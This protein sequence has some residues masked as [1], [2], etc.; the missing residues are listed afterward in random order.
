MSFT[1]GSYEK[2][3]IALF[4]NL[5]YQHQYGPNIERDYYVPFYEEQLI[6]S[7]TTINY[8]KP[9]LA[10]DEAISKLKDIEIGSLPQRNELFMDYL[11]HGIEVSFFD[12]KEQ[13]NDIIYLI[14]YND[15]NI[16][17]NDFKV[18]NQ[19]TFVENS[20]KR[21]DIILFVNGLPLV[22]IELK[23]PSR[24]ETNVS[25]AYLQLRN[26]MK[27]IPSLFVYNVFCVMS[28]MACS[29]AGT[30]TSNEDRY[31]EWKT[32]DGKYE[33]S[34]FI[35]YDTFFEG[36]FIKERFIDIIKN[37]I[38][39]SKEESGAAKI[40]A[41]YHQY[42]AVKKAVERTKKA[43]QGDGKIGVFW[44]TQGSGKSLSMVFYAHLLQDELSQPTIVVITDRNDLDDQL[45]TQFSKCQQFLRQIPIQ[46]KSREDLKSL[47][48]GREANGIIFTTMQKFEE[49]DEPLSL[50]RNIVV[51]TDEAHRG[52][53]GFEEKVNEETGK[54]SIGTARIIHNSLPNASFIGFTGTPIS[55]K[56]RDTT[57]VFGDY[58]DI[59]DMTQAVSDGATCP[60]YYESRVINLNLDKDTLK[61]IDDEYEILASEGATEEQIE[62][63][64]KQMSHLEEILGAPATIDSL[65]KDIINHYEEN[66][67]FELTGKAMIVAY[68]R[69][70]AMSIY[71]RILELRPDWTDKVK[72]VMTGSNKDPEE[73]HDIIGNKQYKKELAKKFK[74]N[75]D[76]MKIAIVVDM[77]LTGFDVPSLATMYVYKPM[78]GHNLMQAIA[79][80]NRVFNDKAGGLVV[81]YIG[82]A[83]ALKQAMHDY[84]VR[85]QKR[86]GNPDIKKTALIKFQEKL[87]VC[88]DIFHGFDYSNFQSG[89]D[90][91]RA[92]IIKGGVNFLMDSNKNDKMQLF[93][94]ESS[95]LHSSITLC[96]SL[97]NEQQRYEAAFF[98]TV[99]ILLS[100][101]TG[102]GKVS[103]KEINARIGEL[104][105]QSVKSEGIINL[106]SDVKA[107]FSIFDTAFL[108]EIS[109]MKEKNIAIELLKKLLAERVTIYQK[110]NLV[111]AEKF[112][113]LLNRALSNYL[114]GLLTNEEVIQELLKLAAEIS[115]SENQG[116]ELGLTA[117]EKS[118]YD[119]LTKP[120]AV[121]D[122]YTNEQLVAMTKELTDALRKN[123]T[124]DWQKKESARA[125]M[126]R[127]IKRLLK[128]YKYPPEEAENALETVIHQCE[129]W[130]DNDSDEYSINES[131][132]KY[133]FQPS[134]YS[135]AADE[136]QEGYNKKNQ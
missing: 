30:I 100:R 5:G 51:M 21:T 34:Q 102:K 123:R 106:F 62:K 118:F 16:K 53:Y 65:C 134:Y 110:T 93:Q 52:Q 60:V 25:E 63:S 50:R 121:Q 75:N 7:L 88:R 126:R 104:I 29:K 32:K 70:I 127:M 103:K 125:G 84:T 27:E 128:K 55:T 47:L 131:I 44:H 136:I 111:Q 35:D 48:A 3:L 73:W 15:K 9:R 20:E 101:M 85:D 24:E 13:R 87:E 43:T 31:M 83:K 78:S 80:V 98:E 10:I 39:F 74:D 117:E 76:P 1:E 124:I 8:G 59:Y 95:L 89:T 96:R 68:S 122:I 12:G 105:K 38:C 41:A 64:K 129:Q 57:E 11:Q 90:N 28:D 36:I 108:E 19:W 112:S 94:K 119:A 33:S 86:F 14:D 49:S 133:N 97:L 135:I 61:A 58:I 46:A 22:V 69:P 107:E 79:R 71:H 77:W 66:R 114:K 6:E 17:R 2:A 4:E 40:L 72:V 54:I 26:Y 91:D 99:R 56:D 45:Y 120:R 113:D 67:Q 81:D 130:T 18:I 42:F 92:Q 23:S 132:Q 115:E 116:N 37:F 109:K 82:I